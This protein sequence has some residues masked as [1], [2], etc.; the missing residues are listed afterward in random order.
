MARVYEQWA[1]VYE[2]FEAAAARDTWQQG[3]VVEL[4]RLQCR[5]ARILDLGAGTG[6]G[7]HV[8][9]SAFPGCEVL[10]LDRSR[11]MLD[12]GNVPENRRVV[13]D[14]SSFDVDPES[15]DFVVSGFDALNALDENA[16]ARCFACVAVAL[17]PGGGFVF[18]YS[19]P[20]LLRHDWAGLVVEREAA[21]GRLV[22]RHHYEDAL[23]RLRVELEMFVGGHSHWTEVHHHYAVGPARMDDLARAAGLVVRHVRDIDGERF[24]PS[25]GTHVYVLELPA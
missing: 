15:F 20:K 23:Q 2:A 14:M 1:E 4:Q 8:L 12:A 9:T 16:L 17:R 11:S 18:D 5:R 13:A 6:I 3:V 25:C 19:S 22:V 21:A 24:S 7:A 10:S